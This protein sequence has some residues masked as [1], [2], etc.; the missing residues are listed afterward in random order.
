MHAFVFLCKNFRGFIQQGLSCSSRAATQK[1][2]CNQ[3]RF[4][5]VTNRQESNPLL[6]TYLAA[7][8]GG[9]G[10]WARP[11][12]WKGSGAL[13]RTNPPC[14]GRA[15]E[16]GGGGRGGEDSSGAVAVRRGEPAPSS[17]AGPRPHSTAG[18]YGHVDAQMDHP[19]E[20]CVRAMEEA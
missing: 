4:L 17:A 7:S 18:R 3:F 14:R 6:T 9:K 19:F 8:R 12:L 1:A 13:L 5:F 15:R 11:R 10:P 20:L 2:K 16:E